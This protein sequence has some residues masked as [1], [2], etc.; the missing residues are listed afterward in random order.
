MAGTCQDHK[1]HR[2]NDSERD[3]TCLAY[4]VDFTD[5][6]LWFALK[7]DTMNGVLGLRLDQGHFHLLSY[8]SNLR[9]VRR[10]SKRTL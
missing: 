1:L 4:R 3:G 5:V 7:V 6:P 10:V 8:W 9:L 2:C